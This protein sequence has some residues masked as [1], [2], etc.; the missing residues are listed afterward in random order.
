MRRQK[1]RKMKQKKDYRQFVPISIVH[2][3]FGAK[4][5]VNRWNNLYRWEDMSE[6]VF[7]K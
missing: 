2:T 4:L 3:M 1:K 6:V 5:N 7:K